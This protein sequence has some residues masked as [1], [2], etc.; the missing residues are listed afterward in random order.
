[1][2]LER[3]LRSAGYGVETVYRDERWPGEWLT[4]SE[5]YYRIY[6]SARERAAHISPL[7]PAQHGNIAEKV[8]TDIGITIA[9]V[10]Y[11]DREGFAINGKY[12]DGVM[13]DAAVFSDSTSPADQL[14]FALIKELQK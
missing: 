3:K 2:I 12:P 8:A 13:R 11:N 10:S 9:P 6:E 7:V 1:M 4:S 14:L 5:L